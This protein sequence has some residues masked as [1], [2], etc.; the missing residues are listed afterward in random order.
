MFVASHNQGETSTTKL[1]VSASFYPMAEFARQVGGNH[2]QVTT[3]VK[4]G[5]EPHDYDPSPQDVATIYRSK[6]L[7]HNGAGLEKWVNKLDL[8]ANKV[9]RVEASKSLNLHAKDA[10][11]TE[12]TSATDP[13]V[14]MDPVLAQKE[15]SAIRD[16]FIKADPAHRKDYESNTAAYNAQLQALDVDFQKGLKQCAQHSVVTSHQALGYLAGEYHFT[17]LGI[18]GLSPDDEPS[19]QELAAVADFVHDHNIDYIFFETLVSPKLS[20][21]IAQETGAQTIAFNPLEGLTP[22][23]ASQGKN[24]ISVQK[25]NLQALRTALH[26]E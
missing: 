20:Q 24:Y 23:E 9:A 1:R 22:D 25:D 5:V 6:V 8:A 10:N 13:H 14:W 2:V 4:P 21:T 16:S 18:A 19:A 15:V 26:C 12:N 3:L 7:I 11:D 17:S